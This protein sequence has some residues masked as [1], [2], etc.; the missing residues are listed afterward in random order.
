MLKNILNLEGVQKL[1][2]ENLIS[3]KGGSQLPCGDHAGRWVWHQG[4]YVCEESI[5]PNTDQ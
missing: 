1:S 4:S 2:L 5:D 3:L